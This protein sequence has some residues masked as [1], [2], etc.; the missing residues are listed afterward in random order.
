ML[1]L[2]RSDFSTKELQSQEGALFL[3]VSIHRHNKSVWKHRV[4]R[5]SRSGVLVMSAAIQFHPSFHFLPML[6][7]NPTPQKNKTVAPLH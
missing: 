3:D 5:A 6:H 4:E 2:G 7:T 1:R